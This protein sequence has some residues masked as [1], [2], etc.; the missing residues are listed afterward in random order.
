ML[1]LAAALSLPLLIAGTPPTAPGAGCP[2]QDP[3]PQGPPQALSAQEQALVARLA[4]QEI[5]LD[6]RRGTC[7]FPV[8]VAVRDDLLEYLLVGAG[9]AAHESAFLTPV[10]PSVLNVALLA[11]GL[12][13]GSNADWTPKDPRP[14]EEEL[15]AGVS[16]YD[17]RAPQ[18]DGLYLYV[19]WK[20]AGET[21][22][23][24]V[25]DVLRDL[26]SGRAMKRHRWVYLGSRMVPSGREGQGDAFAADV[27]RNLINVAF[28][29]E[30]YTLLTAALPECLDQTVWM[31]NA[32][33]VPE[34]GSRLEMVMSRERIEGLPPE[35]ERLL[36]AL[37]EGAPP[38]DGR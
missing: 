21:Y 13:P 27:Y 31:V 17:V 19:G 15:R 14:S 26:G 23:F 18:G 36:P 25:E 29:R 9:G 30:G 28:F 12:E 8:D 33:L 24:R 38:P 2:R 10:S 35:I 34:R 37:V 7:A 22:F 6:L 3:A 16:P 20:S 1:R 5:H 32:W 11:L 4:E